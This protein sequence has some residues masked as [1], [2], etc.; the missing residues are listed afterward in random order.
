MKTIYTLLLSLILGLHLTAQ[1]PN[2]FTVDACGDTYTG[3]S[4]VYFTHNTSTYPLPYT[5][6][7]YNITSGDYEEFVITTNP[8]KFKDL[9]P[10]EYEFQINLGS[11]MVVE[12]FEEINI[13]ENF[14]E[15]KVIELYSKPS[16]KNSPKVISIAFNTLI[17]VFKLIVP[18]FS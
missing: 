4:Y 3:V 16:L 13:V 17:N 11:D 2:I 18:P 15:K 7:Y 12:Y 10:G 14:L 1:A 8:H 9:Y 5:G 6:N